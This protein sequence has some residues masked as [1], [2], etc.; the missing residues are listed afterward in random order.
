MGELEAA[1]TVEVA[2]V[3][4]GFTGDYGGA[5]GVRGCGRWGSVG[6]VRWHVR[7]SHFNDDCGGKKY[8][9]GGGEKW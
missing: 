5:D 8:R 2:V 9:L 1:R 6:K 7:S 3:D 4:G